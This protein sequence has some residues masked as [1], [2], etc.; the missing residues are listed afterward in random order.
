MKKIIL[1]FIAMLFG[2]SAFSQTAKDFMIASHLD[3]IKSDN[4]G[5]FEKVQVSAEL[6]Y[7]LSRKFAATGGME[8]WTEG[9]EFSVV[10]G[11]R[12]HPVPEAFIRAR[13]L[14]GANDISIGGGWAKPLK[15]NW[16]FEAMGDVYTKGHIAI[17]AGFAYIIRT[18]P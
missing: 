4:E 6:N 2:L 16:R 10:V 18:N 9:D 11:A 12:W 3:L 14:I 5:Y 8:Y 1:S 7:F 17:R 15:E 13:G